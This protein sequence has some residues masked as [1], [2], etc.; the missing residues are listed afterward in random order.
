[1]AG[2]A[3]QL[4]ASVESPDVGTIIRWRF[5]GGPPPVLAYEDAPYA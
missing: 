4:E 5:Q 2:L 3:L 1:M